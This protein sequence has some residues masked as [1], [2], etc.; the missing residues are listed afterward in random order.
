V[1]RGRARGQ[2]SARRTSSFGR[3]SHRR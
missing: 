2:K 1:E 3:G